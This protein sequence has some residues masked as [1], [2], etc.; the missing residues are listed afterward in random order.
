MLYAVNNWQIFCGA[1]VSV[2]TPT[3]YL[4]PLSLQQ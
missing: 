1:A 3:I 2:A 4:L